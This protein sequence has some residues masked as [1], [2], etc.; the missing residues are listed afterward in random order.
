MA[1]R[2]MRVAVIDSGIY[3]DHP[4]INGVAGGVAIDGE[5]R[6]HA[7]FTDRLGHGTAVAAAIRDQAPEAELFAVKI[8][9]RQLSSNIGALVAAIEW[10]ARSG[11]RLANLSLGS[12]KIE[13]EQALRAA[14]NAA[15]A[16]KLVIVAARDDEGVRYYPGS[17]PGV[18]PVQVDWTLARQE[19]Q[20]VEADGQLVIR[21]SGLPREIPG[22]P[23]ARNLH[24]VSFAVANAT[25]IIAR[26]IAGT[27]AASPREI[28]MRLRTVAT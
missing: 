24:G 3:A 8:F 12:P 21:A 2:G 25:G 26:A 20:V 14:V 13:H 28:L 17:L 1:S 4:H 23:P 9:D 18:V 7:D 27:D 10:A 11:M 15:A 22:V 5:G 16:D 19:F 6:E